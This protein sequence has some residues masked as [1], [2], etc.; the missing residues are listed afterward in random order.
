MIEF[1]KLKKLPQGQRLKKTVKIF[2]Q[3]EKALVSNAD[4]S[5]L[6]DFYLKLRRLQFQN[7]FL[8]SKNV[9]KALLIRSCT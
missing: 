5:L 7:I 2:E 1:F 6:D 8:R 3:L 4:E 9:I